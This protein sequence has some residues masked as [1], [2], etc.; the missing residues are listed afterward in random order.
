[1]LL[2]HRGPELPSGYLAGQ[3][4]HNWPTTTRHL[5]ILEAAGILSVR[6]AGRN[7]VYRLERDR[8]EQVVGGWLGML[9]EPTPQRTWRSTGPRSTKKGTGS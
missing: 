7:C 5:H 6:R 2:A 9:E 8:L 3:L 1:M 4:E